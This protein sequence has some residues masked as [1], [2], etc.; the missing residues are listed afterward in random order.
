MGSNSG[1]NSGWNW[2]HCSNFE[3]TALHF[4]HGRIL[5]WASAWDIAHAQILR[6]TIALVLAHGRILTWVTTWVTA[7]RFGWSLTCTSGIVG[8]FVLDG[9]VGLRVALCIEGKFVGFGIVGL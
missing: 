9:S 4:A 1:S 2:G 6:R 3:T 7:R 8:F 5:T